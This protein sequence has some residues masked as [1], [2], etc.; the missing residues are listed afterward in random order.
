MTVTGIH[1]EEA[2]VKA[3]K[4]IIDDLPASHKHVLQFVIFHL[5]R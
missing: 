5:A 4:E 2:R 3:L 1:E